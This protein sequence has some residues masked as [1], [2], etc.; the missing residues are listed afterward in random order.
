MSSSRLNA[1][2]GDNIVAGG[3]NLNE[4]A[5]RTETSKEAKIYGVVPKRPTSPMMTKLYNTKYVH[6]MIVQNF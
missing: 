5:V 4:K 6:F 1:I 3:N 2:I